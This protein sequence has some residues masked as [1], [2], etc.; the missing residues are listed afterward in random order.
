MV[1]R[2]N[3]TRGKA[4]EDGRDPGRMASSFRVRSALCVVPRAHFGARVH[5]H[6]TNESSMNQQK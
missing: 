3:V 2:V 5:G 4:S 6:S 1:E